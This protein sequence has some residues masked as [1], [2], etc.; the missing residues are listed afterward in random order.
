[1]DS[2]GARVHGIEVA[3]AAPLRRRA[4]APPGAAFHVARVQR[5]EANPGFRK[6]HG[7][8]GKA[9]LKGE[10]FAR[11]VQIAREHH[12]DRVGLRLARGEECARHALIALSGGCFRALVDVETQDVD[13]R[14]GGAKR[15]NRLQQIQHRHAAASVLI[16]V[17]PPR[18]MHELLARGRGAIS[19]EE[20]IKRRRSVTRHL[21]RDHHRT[22]AGS[23]G[24]ERRDERGD[25]SGAVHV[26]EEDRTVRRE[27]LLE[28]TDVELG[29]GRCLSAL[30]R[31]RCLGALNRRGPRCRPRRAA[32]TS[33]GDPENQTKLTARRRPW[34]PR[35]RSPSRC[36]SP[37]CSVPSR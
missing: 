24:R 7:H 22:T 29:R 25:F 27:R 13:L 37:C 28:R 32:E 20:G 15:A 18:I 14:A 2:G 35:D 3:R 1:M 26:A 30:N 21:K 5:D 17:L 12:E 9:R 10:A 16:P 6:V 23:R 33:G 36:W 8:P 31:G 11:D 4:A 34:W 19:V